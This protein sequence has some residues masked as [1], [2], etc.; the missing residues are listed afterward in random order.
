MTAALALLDDVHAMTFGLRKVGGRILSDAA[1][2][3]L[4]RYRAELRSADRFAL[5][6][7]AVRFICEASH[8]AGRREDH[9][10]ARA[11]LARLPYDSCWFEF[12]L[13]AKLRAFETMGT[14][15]KAFDPAA[16]SPR[17]GY[18]FSRDGN[19]PTRWV[20]HDFQIVDDRALPGLIAYV[21]DPEGDEM[22]PVRGSDRWHSPTLGLRKG[23][24]KTVARVND[25]AELYPISP[26][27][28]PY[29][30]FERSTDGSPTGP[31]WLAARTGVIADPFWDAFLE[32]DKLHESLRVD[33]RERQGELRWLLTLLAS[34]NALPSKTRTAA[35]RTGRRAVGANLLP[36]LP[37]SVV[38]ID[39]PRENRTVW[40]RAFDNAVTVAH[41]R[42]HPVRGHWRVDSGLAL[43]ERCEL[44]VRWIPAHSRGDPTL[45]VVERAAHLV[46]GPK[47]S[48][49]R[50]DDYDA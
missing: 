12:D 32:R 25:S 17:I 20:C 39:V 50:L 10:A 35:T 44:L 30:V 24:P 2:N 19:S 36:Y 47:S 33:L 42:W 6:D 41:R 8:D 31:E 18:L 11:V 48:T 45:G 23:F 3:V 14:L 38:T 27:M 46:H 16:V 37:H 13:H 9:G 4:A 21:F 22:M 5:D 40:M 28:V 34:L 49:P 7:E 15:R 1:R 29:G 43:C 26:E